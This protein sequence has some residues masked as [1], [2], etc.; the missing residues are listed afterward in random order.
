ML[1][2]KDGRLV[3]FGSPEEILEKEL[4]ESIYGVELMEVEM[5]RKRIYL[6]KTPARPW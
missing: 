3:R 1:L 6:P 5:E 2:M 4:L